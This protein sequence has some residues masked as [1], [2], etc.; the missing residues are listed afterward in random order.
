MKIKNENDFIGFL[1]S[2]KQSNGDIS[3]SHILDKSG[4]ND[5][6]CIHYLKNLESK[7]YIKNID[8]ETY[9]IYPDGISAHIPTAKKFFIRIRDIILYLLGLVTPYVVEAIIE[10]IKKL[11]QKPWYTYQK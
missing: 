3:V 6:D 2:I 10:I 8:T 4:L 9:H 7:G 1:I 5:I 11:L